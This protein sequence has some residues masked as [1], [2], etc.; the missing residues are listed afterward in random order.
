MPD[1]TPF[2]V[3]T[4]EIGAHIYP[5]RRARGYQAAPG[6]FYIWNLTREVGFDPDGD[7]VSWGSC[8][9]RVIVRGVLH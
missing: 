5:Q 3:G 8:N 2:T 6:I 7:Y 4:D 1:L 9:E